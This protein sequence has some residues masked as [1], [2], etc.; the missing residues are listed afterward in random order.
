MKEI[1]LQ[2]IMP[3]QQT[4]VFVLFGDNFV[5]EMIFTMS[6]YSVRIYDEE[7]NDRFLQDHM[8]YRI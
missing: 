5:E 6:F 3:Q 4:L 8:R 7:R 1:D 2:A